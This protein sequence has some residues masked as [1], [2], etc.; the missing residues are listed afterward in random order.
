M[1]KVSLLCSLFLLAT[2]LSAAA[3]PGFPSPAGW[4]HNAPPATTDPTRVVEQWHIAGDVASVTF[5]KDTGTAYSDALAAIEKNFSTN[6]I[7]PATDK[8]VPCQGKTG[9]EI[10][11]AVGPEGHQLIIH[12]VIV[13]DGTGIDTVTY[14]RADGTVFD[15]DVKKSEDAYC[16]ESGS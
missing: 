7:R 15:P 6:K 12:R 11:F 9:H 2:G 10:D 5:I 13:P 8:D 1:R 14:A 4:S 16:A 3:N